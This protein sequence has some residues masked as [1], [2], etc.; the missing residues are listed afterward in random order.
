MLEVLV[1][2]C[3]PG[4]LRLGFSRQRVAVWVEVF[5]A[6]FYQI[7]F[8]SYLIAKRRRKWVY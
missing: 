5:L 7:I 2:A 8:F 3:T 6:I 4:L 1:L